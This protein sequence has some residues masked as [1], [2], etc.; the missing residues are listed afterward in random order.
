MLQFR[1]CNESFHFQYKC[2]YS[3]GWFTL[4][5]SSITWSITSSYLFWVSEDYGKTF[6]DITDLINNTFIQTEFGVAIG[7]GNS[8]KVKIY[9]STVILNCSESIIPG[10]QCN[11]SVCGVLWNFD[12]C[13]S[14]Q[15]HPSGKVV[16]PQKD[17][18]DVTNILPFKGVGSFCWEINTLL[19]KSSSKDM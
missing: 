5:F 11:E 10:F 1:K 12:V 14:K 7:P 16:P 6:Q 17:E 13:T 8:G 9:F 18:D 15:V 2:W 19:S 4:L 3:C